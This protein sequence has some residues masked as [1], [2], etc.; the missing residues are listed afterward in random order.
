MAVITEKN[1]YKQQKQ[2]ENISILPVFSEPKNWNLQI[3]NSGVSKNG[4]Q[5]VQAS[6]TSFGSKNETRVDESEIYTLDGIRS[7]LIRQEDSIIFS[8]VERAQ[9]CYNEDTYDPNA[10]F[11]DGF[12]GSLVEFMVKET[13]KVHAQVGRYKSPDE[14]PFF[15]KDYLTYVAP[16]GIPTDININL[17]IW[18]IYF[19]DLLP[20][21]VK[22]GNDGNCGSAA[23]CDSTCLQARPV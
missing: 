15:P 23:T 12:K 18:D 7:S 22:E 16:I 8:L 17:K 11:M 10:F 1:N 13:E 21:L 14:H 5:S 4:V 6:A 2:G 19:K 3:S 20:R 9:F